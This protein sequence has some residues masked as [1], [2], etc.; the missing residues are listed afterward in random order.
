MTELAKTEAAAP[1]S[2]EG[3]LAE[4]GRGPV[5][6]QVLPALETGGVERGTVDVA[7][8]LAGAG[9]LALVAS[10]GGPMV[11]ELERV[12][13]LHVTL[14]VHSKNPFVMARNVGR[15]ADLI[16]AHAVEIVHARSR[17]PAWSALAAARRT[18]RPL[19]T[20]FHGTYGHGNPL[21]RRYNAVMTRGDVV[22]AI[23]N[24]IAQHIRETYGLADGRVRV[25]H[26]GVD[27]D[28]FSP[29]RVSAE[30]M[31]QLA[32]RWRVSQ[33][34]PLVMLPGRLT[35][36]K[37]QAL[38]IEA[39][40]RL[41]RHDIRCVLV[42]SDQGRRHYRRA[43]ERLIM[44]RG[45]EDVVLFTGECRDMPAAYMLA[46]VVVSA[47]TEPEAFGR[48]A[49]EAQAMGC[50][51][52]ASD[53]GAARETVLAG[54]TGWLYRP[55]DADALGEAVGQALAMTSEARERLAERAVAHIAANFSKE[56]MCAQTLSVYEELRWA[57]AGAPAEAVP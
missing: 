14:P 56:K 7:A 33:E 20:T 37:G 8:A 45:L 36:W 26:R 6:L 47:S 3:P 43:L 39:L 2:G 10:S 1:Q 51:V 11:R 28:L 46:D 15:L 29:R 19:V 57:G 18:E 38:L 40:A 54:D 21:K 16:E 50:P 9:G 49:A 27:L 12:G 4:G 53:H 25:I 48:V 5:V 55:G 30:R 22:I 13:G 32:E 17:A 24:F 44:R 23:S 35:R 52:V 41:D 31:I 42:G 34:E